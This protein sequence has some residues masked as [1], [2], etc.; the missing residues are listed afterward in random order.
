MTQLALDFNAMRERAKAKRARGMAIAAANNRHQRTRARVAALQC[1]GTLGYGTIS[2][3]RAWCH[4]KEIELEWE[5]P[6]T[7]ALFQHPWF[8]AT[9]R[10]ENAFHEGSNARR[11]MV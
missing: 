6:W 11:V 8:E 9:G 5:K 4:E 3:V 1:L 10:L 2:H 7:G